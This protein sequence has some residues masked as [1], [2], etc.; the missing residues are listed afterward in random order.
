MA[1]SSFLGGSY[2]IDYDAKHK[3]LY[4]AYGDHGVLLRYV[5]DDSDVEHPR[6]RDRVEVFHGTVRTVKV[7]G[8]Y[9]FVFGDGISFA[10]LTEAETLLEFFPIALLGE[11][12]QEQVVTRTA[13]KSN[14]TSLL[15][16]AFIV[17]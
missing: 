16:D 10:K 2:G 3:L 5:L 7:A 6:I 1:H 11:V 17:E 4:I 14:V 15:V 8:E 13:A 12:Y 9:L